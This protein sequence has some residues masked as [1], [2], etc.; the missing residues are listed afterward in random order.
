MHIFIQTGAFRC[1]RIQVYIVRKR[2]Y[3]NMVHAKFNKLIVYEVLA[4][5]S[6][7]LLRS[8]NLQKILKRK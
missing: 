3:S 1:M 4:L 2:I 8:R 6:R 7:N 5:N